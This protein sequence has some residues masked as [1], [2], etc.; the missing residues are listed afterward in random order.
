[1]LPDSSTIHFAY[2]ETNY[3]FSHEIIA[4]FMKILSIFLCEEIPESLHNWLM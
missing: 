1:M 3:T 4:K 2:A